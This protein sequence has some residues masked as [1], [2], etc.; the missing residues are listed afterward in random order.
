M[1]HRYWNNSVNT[2]GD[3]KFSAKSQ[4]DIVSNKSKCWPD[5][6]GLNMYWSIYTTWLTWRSR[7][8]QFIGISL[9]FSLCHWRSP[10]IT[11]HRIGKIVFS[12]LTVLYRTTLAIIL[13]SPTSKMSAWFHVF[14]LPFSFCF[15]FLL[16]H[17]QNGQT[18]L[19]VP[20]Q[21]LFVHFIHFHHT[22]LKEIF[23][24]FTVELNTC[25][26]SHSHRMLC[27]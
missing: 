3:Q 14:D 17:I 4:I 23:C 8:L 9:R 26:L 20:V 11:R 24:K 15:R 5:F 6:S 19:A 18:S 16:T 7:I 27:K 13:T 22:F 2:L 25:H 21:Q 12:F 1:N 10:C